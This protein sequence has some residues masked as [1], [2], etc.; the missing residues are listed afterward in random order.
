MSAFMDPK[1]EQQV[2]SGLR[3]G[4]ADAWRSFYDA[5]CRQVWHAVARMMGPGD[6]DVADVVQETFMAAARSAGRYDPKRGSP[7]MWLYG[8][9]RNHVALHYRKQGRP[10]RSRPPGGK[11]ED[12]N[13]QI[14][15][16][17]EGREQRAGRHPAI[18]RT[19]RLGAFRAE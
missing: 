2:V 8:I 9:A 17:L 14:V 6:P 3:E 7:W 15:E 12:N 1:R 13:R 5:Y 19:C 16:W 4:D 11:D 18:G 10:D